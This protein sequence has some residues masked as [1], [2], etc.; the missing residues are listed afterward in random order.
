MKSIFLSAGHSITDPGAVGNGLKEADVAV[1]T[2]NLVSYYLTQW[3]VP[4]EVDGRFTE[5]IPLALAAKKARRHPLAVEFHCNAAG[6]P[7]ARGCETLSAPDDMELGAKLCE[8]MA[9]ALG[10]KNR[11]AKPENAGHHSRLAFVQAGGIIVEL[12]FI[13]NP[14]DVEAYRAKKWLLARGIAEVLA[15]ASAS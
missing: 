8:A 9:A 1:E 7:A 4:H 10:T 11:G 2:R 5:N 15:E 6:T 3:Q 12:F 14:L 13:T